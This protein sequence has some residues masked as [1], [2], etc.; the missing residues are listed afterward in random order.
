MKDFNLSTSLYLAITIILFVFLDSMFLRFSSFMIFLLCTSFKKFHSVSLGPRVKQTTRLMADSPK[1]TT[2][3]KEKSMKLLDR[4]KEL[5]TVHA[6]Q[7]KLFTPFV[8]DNQ[9][10]GY[11]NE[12]MVAKL[13]NFN[14]IFVT[15]A[16]SIQGKIIS[17][18]DDVCKLTI[19]SRTAI[20]HSAILQ[21]RNEGYID[22][23]RDEFVPALMSFSSK[24][25]FLIE[26]AAY[27]M[28]GF[29]GYGTFSYYYYMCTHACAI[30]FI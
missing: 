18:N 14:D 20:I 4:I 9:L 13:S 21:L 11:L 30:Y 23:W 1:T 3:T 16:D 10:Y 6:D 17:L 29:K 27:S 28:F 8:V 7:L 15:K 24:P 12:D 19:E 25:A 26:R 5:N 22:G 2:L